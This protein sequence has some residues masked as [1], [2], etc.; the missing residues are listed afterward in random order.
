MADQLR[1]AIAKSGRSFHE[2]GPKRAC[3]PCRSLVRQGERDLRLESASRLAGVLGLVADVPALVNLPEVSRVGRRGRAAGWRKSSPR[4]AKIERRGRPHRP[5]PIA[6]D[7]SS[8]GPSQREA[9][10]S[11]RPV[12]RVAVEE[13][14]ELCP[15]IGGGGSHIFR[16][17][18]GVDPPETPGRTHPHRRPRS[19]GDPSR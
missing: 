5:T 6:G 2:L 17:F 1:S 3:I 8:A 14:D 19:A 18:G 9:A 11:V 15:R 4:W 7:V 12:Q 13:P 10:R 16:G